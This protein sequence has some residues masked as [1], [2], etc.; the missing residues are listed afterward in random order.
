MDSV[1]SNILDAE[2][3]DYG[4]NTYHEITTPAADDD[5]DN[6]PIGNDEDTEDEEDEGPDSDRWR[7][8]TAIL[9]TQLKPEQLLPIVTQTLDLWKSLGIDLPLFL[10]ALTLL[11]SVELPTILRNW[12]APPRTAKKG[13]RGMS[14]RGTI[15]DFCTSLTRKRINADIARSLPLFS[16]PTEDVSTKA[17]VKIQYNDLIEE[18]KS[19]APFMWSLLSEMAYS[20]K[21]RERNNT[22]CP[23]LMILN[24]ISQAQYSRSQ[25]RGKL[26]KLHALYLKASGTSA[27]AFDLVHMLGICMSHK[28]A[29]DA[30]ETLADEKMREAQLAV[31]RPGWII[32]H[33]NVN[34]PMR[35]FSQRLHNQNHFISGTAT[36]IWIL[37]KSAYQLPTDAN[38]DLNSHR[39]LHSSEI[40]DLSRVICPNNIVLERIEAQNIQHVLRFLVDSPQFEK[41]GHKDHPDLKPPPSVE[42]LPLGTKS[43]VQQFILKTCEIEEAS[44]DG[45]EKVMAEIFRQ[46]QLDTEVEQKQTGTER[47]IPWLGDQLT[48]SRLRG[49]FRFHA[50]DLNSF[51]RL[52]YMLPVFGWF[53]LLMALGN[54]LHAQY[55]GTS[56]GVGGLRHAF[57]LLGRKGLANQS[58]KGPFWHHLDEAL[59]HICEAHFRACWLQ[60]G[61][62]R[63]IE[64]LLSLAP[65]TL[66]T[67]ATTIVRQYAS[68]Q[69][70]EEMAARDTESQDQQLRQQIMWNADV[71]VYIELRDAIRSGDVGRME[72]ITPTL[73]LRFAGGGNSNY[74]IE[75]LEMMQGMYKEW[76]PAIV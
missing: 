30:Y 22:K 8:R 74:T 56:A 70:I 34:L 76:P 49:L 52:D 10:L 17:L 6:E 39:I 72:D 15:D 54:S 3:T 61:N 45:T 64:E 60:E 32:S 7:H 4:S 9:R 67:M 35:A 47:I 43:K 59:H 71:L 16:S 63:S 19:A 13:S 23:D 50:E 27:R 1:L 48:A 53:H 46:L 51:E 66:R 73:L 21:Q 28:W 55:Y 44:Y 14:A 65:A 42:A 11:R 62:V 26:Q 2:D 38:Q 25:R 69:P 18:T 37:P 68:R 12:Y 57:D 40:F 58:T 5:D 36:T 24:M 75:L 29:C 20:K 33:D 41:Y 31:Q